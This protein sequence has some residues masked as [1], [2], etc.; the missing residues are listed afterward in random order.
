[1]GLIDHLGVEYQERYRDP[2]YTEI[3]TGR[4]AT[5]NREQ[6][7]QTDWIWHNINQKVHAHMAYGFLES[8]GNLC[9]AFGPLVQY[10]QNATGTDQPNHIDAKE[11][12]TLPKSMSPFSLTSLSFCGIF[13]GYTAGFNAIIEKYPEFRRR[14]EEDREPWL[15]I[16]RRAADQASLHSKQYRSPW[17]Q[18][19]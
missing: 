7:G 15:S 8:H 6:F 17:H 1:M 5:I 3:F 12:A 9:A 4:M 10:A 13:G 11:L 2:T 16:A 19:V 18:Q 14:I